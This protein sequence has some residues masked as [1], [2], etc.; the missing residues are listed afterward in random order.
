[1]H[2]DKFDP[3]I[4]NGSWINGR[5]VKSESK[6][7]VI[8]PATEQVVTALYE[9]TMEQA[10][11]AITSAEE[12]FR[13]WSQTTAQERS[14]ILRRWYELLLTHIDALAEL[15][16]KEQGKP[17]GEAKAEIRYGAD[18][19]RWYSEECRRLYGE[20][21]P[22]PTQNKRII[23][24]RQPIG[25]TAAITPW[26]FPNAMIA[27]KAA[28]AIAAGCTMVVKPSELT[29]LSA[30]ALAKL[31]QMAGLPDG[32]LQVLV[33]TD[34]E[35]IGEMLTTHPAIQALSFTGST[36]VGRKLASRCGEHLKRVTLELGGNAPFI[37]FD[38][39]DLGV[40][41]DGLMQAKFR[42]AGQTCICSNRVLVQDSILTPL[43]EK[44]HA[45][46]KKLRVGDGLLEHTQIGPL[47]QPQ[48]CQKVAH[49]LDDASRKG[50][51]ITQFNETPPTHGYFC[52]PAIVT[53]VT[54]NMAIYREEIFGPVVAIMSF[55]T[56]DEAIR[57][58]ND[59]QAGL[60]AYLY[61]QNP[62][63]IWRM[64][65]QLEYG[66][67]GINDAAISN[68]AAPFGGIKASG[69][70]REGS[71]HGLDEFTYLKYLSWGI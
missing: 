36:E 24:L 62:S 69:F 51:K 53:N 37:V 54:P 16:T 20:T 47:I 61:T 11:T 38:D 67:V 55:A 31:G 9:V 17:V 19:I 13:H 33:G 32:V 35:K 60:A 1:M 18:Y 57:L 30:L 71:R 49:L 21:I 6:F 56:E 42:N 39:A 52:A 4:G 41:V 48:A 2:T 45:K 59:T 28:A 58:A 43:L 44:L 68:P 26:N 15:L 22:G 8:N 12:A 3:L 64:V 50:A 40:A 27:R 10:E 70:G 66:M 23:V 46:V 29:P 7:P 65:D 14:D 5:W 63:R 25:V 34:A